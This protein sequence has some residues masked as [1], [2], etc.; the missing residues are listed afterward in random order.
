M[1][2][3]GIFSFE[4]QVNTCLGPECTMKGLKF[5]FVHL[6]DYDL[7]LPYRPPK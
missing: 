4:R 7:Y 3:R 5:I 6:F 1:I 2:Q